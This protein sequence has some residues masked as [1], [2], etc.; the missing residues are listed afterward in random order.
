ME[1]HD[2]QRDEQDESEDQPQGL[3]RVLAARHPTEV[4]RQ[5]HAQTNHSVFAPWCEVCV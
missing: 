3:R 1:V 4:E 5:N 2:G